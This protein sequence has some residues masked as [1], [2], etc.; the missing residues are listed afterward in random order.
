MAKNTDIELQREVI[1]S[2]YVRNHT[3]EGT[4]R[5]LIPDLGRIKSLGTD[6]VWLMPIHPIGVIARKGTLGSPYANMDYRAVNPEYGTLDDF[7]ALCA[8]VHDA[9]MKIIIDV[10][11]NHTSPDSVLWKTHPEFFYKRPDGRPGNHVGDWTDIIDLDYTNK[12]LWDYQIESLC[13]WAQ[14]VDGF[15]CDVASFVPVEF[16]KRA[17]ERVEKVRNGCIWL[18]ESVHRSFGDYCRSVGM[19]SAKDSELFEAFDIEYEY[20]VHEAFDAYLAGSAPLSTYMELVSFQDFAY[21]GRYNKLRFLENHDQP[22]IASRVRETDRLV[23]FTAMMYFMKGATLIYAGQER[24]CDHLPA[25]FD[26]DTISFDTG[27]DLSPLMR[28]L[29]EIKKTALEPIDSFTA[30]SYGDTAV[31]YRRGASVKLGVFPLKCDKGEIPVSVPDGEYENL[32]SGETAGVSGG[33][34]FCDGKPI[35][36]KL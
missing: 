34:L 27:V 28:R 10:V 30:L 20:D 15:R 33:K 32:I 29:Y 8:A 12:A 1:Y 9:G 17:R 25:L 7:K 18:A 2:V 21:P 26:K 22:R 36:I 24:A 19:Y 23:S 3:P 4:F 5:A 13:F 6:I 14:Y 35:I 31:M 16:W 11:Y